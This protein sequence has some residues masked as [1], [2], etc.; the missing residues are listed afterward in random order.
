MA[1]A[2]V[3]TAVNQIICRH[4]SPGLSLSKPRQRCQHHSASQADCQGF[5]PASSGIVD[6]SVPSA[7]TLRGAPAPAMSSISY[8]AEPAAVYLRTPRIR[9]PQP[10]D[11][12]SRARHLGGHHT[13]RSRDPPAPTRCLTDTV[14]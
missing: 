7:P 3:F 4:A 12:T 6:M 9:H 8:P 2:A 11:P 5:R 13:R 1:I 14:A 10:L